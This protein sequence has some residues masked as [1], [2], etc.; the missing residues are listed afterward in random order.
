[1]GFTVNDKA[2]VTLSFEGCIHN[3]FGRRYS[4]G[5]CYFYWLYSHESYECQ[6]RERTLKFYCFLTKGVKGDHK[7]LTFH[8]NH[9]QST[10]KF[11]HTSS[12]IT[13]RI[14]CTC[15]IIFLGILHTS[16]RRSPLFGTSA[17]PIQFVT[18]WTFLVWHPGW[19]AFTFTP[20]TRH[21]FAQFQ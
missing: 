13:T 2:T 11:S 3:E 10:L 18:F 19:S 14:I 20:P 16:N 7:H 17:Q 9:G 5:Q 15:I 8:Q 4:E 12:R 1:M 21:T 6:V